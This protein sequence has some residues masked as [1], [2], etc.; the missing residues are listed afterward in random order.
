[1]TRGTP[2]AASRRT[3]SAAE[4]PEASSQP[5]VTTVPSLASPAR[6]HDV[7]TLHPGLPPA[8]RRLRRVVREHGLARVVALHQSH[9]A[10]TADIDS[11][12]DVHGGAWSPR[13]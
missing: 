2:R 12:D 1:M 4:I 13:R 11:G 8:S 6:A 9:A 7:Q 5:S 3:S 10:A